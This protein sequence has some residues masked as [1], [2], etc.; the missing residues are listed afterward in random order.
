M[1]PNDDIFLVRQQ[2]LEYLMEAMEDFRKELRQLEIMN[3]WFYSDARDKLEDAIRTLKD[4]LE[5][6]TDEQYDEEDEWDE[7]AERLFAELCIERERTFDY[8]DEDEDGEQ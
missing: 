3:E 5:I 8:L 6:E 7:E 1:Q 2:D 4:I